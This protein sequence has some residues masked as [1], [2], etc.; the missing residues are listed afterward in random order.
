MYCTLSQIF[1]IFQTKTCQ[2]SQL[3]LNHGIIDLWP[4]WCPGTPMALKFFPRCSTTLHTFLRE[5]NL[6]LSF[7]SHPSLTR[8]LGIYFSTPSHYIFA[9]QAALYGDLYDVIVSDV[10][11]FIPSEKNK[12]TWRLVVRNLDSAQTRVVFC[13]A[14]VQ[15]L[16][17]D[18]LSHLDMI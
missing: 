12:Q 9:Q 18:T 6:S 5:Y 4:S 15:V 8:A 14:Y 7:S 3:I 11:L 17:K 2:I 10:S 13:F 1:S 16:L